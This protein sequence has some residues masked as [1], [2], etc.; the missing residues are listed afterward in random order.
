MA[1]FLCQKKDMETD[2]KQKFSECLNSFFNDFYRSAGI[3]SDNLTPRYFKVNFVMDAWSFGYTLLYSNGDFFLE[4]DLINNG[5][6]E[7]IFREKIFSKFNFL[8]KDKRFVSSNGGRIIL[9]S[10]VAKEYLEVTKIIFIA[11]LWSGK[12]FLPKTN[13]IFSKISSL[14]YHDFYNT[15]NLIIKTVYNGFNVLQEENLHSQTTANF[16]NE[17]SCVEIDE[18]VWQ[19]SDELR[20]AYSN[21]LKDK[22]SGFRIVNKNELSSFKTNWDARLERM[23]WHKLESRK[24]NLFLHYFFESYGFKSD[25]R[26]DENGRLHLCY[27]P[28]KNLIYE[29]SLIVDRKFAEVFGE[30]RNEKY[31]GFYVVKSVT[32]FK[33]VL[34]A[35]FVLG[36]EFKSAALKEFLLEGE[37]RKIYDELLKTNLDADELLENY[38]NVCVS[39]LETVALKLKDAIFENKILR[40]SWEKFSTRFPFVKCADL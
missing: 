6:E 5:I 21:F 2:Y 8:L 27:I 12:W 38:I 7:S 32:N 26:C 22:N 11:E 25:V 13:E 24:T 4:V 23:F 30:N 3:G 36:N 10:D 1:I 17:L 35:L 31:L 39:E 20:I 40:E 14:I 29:N 15:L 9:K 19:V 16:V 33:D 34:R 37:T 18:S 28:T